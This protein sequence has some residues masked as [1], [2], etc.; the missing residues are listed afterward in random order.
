MCSLPLRPVSVARAEV[1]WGKYV[2]DVARRAWLSSSESHS[3]SN[4]VCLS[5]DDLEQ[6]AG[7]DRREVESPIQVDTA[8]WSKAG[9]L[10]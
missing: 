7:A 6:I 9:Q 4:Q 10:D 2:I 8:T 3:C 1:V 5:D